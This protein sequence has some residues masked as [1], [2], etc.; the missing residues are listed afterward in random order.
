LILRGAISSVAGG[1]GDKWLGTFIHSPLHGEE[2]YVGAIVIT[3]FLS[4]SGGGQ[5]WGPMADTDKTDLACN[6]Y[7][8]YPDSQ[9]YDDCLLNRGAP[10][11]PIGLQSISRGGP[12]DSADPLDPLSA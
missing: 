12:R 9:Q 2:D 10:N 5:A 11:A 3:L 4:G 7:G 6:G 8:F 1:L